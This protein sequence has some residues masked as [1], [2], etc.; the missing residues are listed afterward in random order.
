[1]GPAPCSR[2]HSA[3]RVKKT[4]CRACA[5]AHEVMRQKIRRGAAV[6]PPAKCPNCRTALRPFERGYCSALCQ[7]SASL[8]RGMQAPR[9]KDPC[10]VKDCANRVHLYRRCKRHLWE[11]SLGGAA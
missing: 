7:R 2:C 5:T 4:W 11:M 10:S 6:P 3:P 9:R 1:M 8:L